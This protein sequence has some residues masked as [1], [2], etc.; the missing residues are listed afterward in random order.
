MW[1]ELGVAER[2]ALLTGTSPSRQMQAEIPRPEVIAGATPAHWAARSI[3]EDLAAWQEGEIVWTEMSH[4]LLFHGTLGTGKTFLAR[5]MA[6][7]S[8]IALVEGSFAVWQSAGHLGQMLAAMI[9]CFDEA[10][11]QAPCILFIDEIDAAGSRFDGDHHNMNY[12]AQVVNG[13]LQQIDRLALT[14]GVILV[15]ACNQLNR[16]DPAITRPGRFDQTVRMPLP[17]LQDII[18]ILSKVLSGALPEGEIAQLAREAVGKTPAELD[19]AMRATKADARRQQVAISPVLLRR[20]LGIERPDPALLHRI[21]VHEA[22]HALAAELLSPGAVVKVT[23][24]SR[25]GLTER[26]PALQHLTV[27]E[28]ETELLI[29]MSGRAAERLAL[30][31]ISGGAGGD[32]RSDLAQASALVLQMDRELGLGQNGDGWIGP[33]D[34]H[35]LTSEEKQRLR[36]KLEKAE[37]RAHALLTPNKEVLLKIAN[38]LTERR[39]MDASDL[40]HWFAKTVSCRPS[41]QAPAPRKGTA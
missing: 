22:G 7:A 6:A 19:A 41:Q 10:I 15:G 5:Q 28:I 39:E 13:F 20:H 27:K 33:A 3:V 24:S 21:A 30:G 11:A 1:S 32:T 36:T 37:R 8:G 35:R 31:S 4:S 9:K 16:L 38:E 14:P 17:S 26:R 34:M 29:L 18:R 23:V 40:A 12:R 25:D 2:I